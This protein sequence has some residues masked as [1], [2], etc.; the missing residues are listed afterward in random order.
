MTAVLA[1]ARQVTRVFHPEPVGALLQLSNGTNAVLAV[2]E[3]GYQITTG[4]VIAVNP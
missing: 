4:E 3:P 2:G 1:D